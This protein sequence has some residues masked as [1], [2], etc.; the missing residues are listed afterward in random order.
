MSDRIHVVNPDGYLGPS[1]ASEIEYAED[2]R[3]A[4]HVRAQQHT[5]LP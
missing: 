5:T 3:Q 2:K 1:T 4:S